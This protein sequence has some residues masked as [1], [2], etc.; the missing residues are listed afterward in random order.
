MKS[1][2]KKLIF[3]SKKQYKNPYYLARSN[4]VGMGLAFAPFPGQIPL[5][6]G[7]WLLGRKLKWRFSLAI[8]IMWSFIS[9]VFTNIPLFYLY[10]I[11]GNFLRGLPNTIKYED[12]GLSLGTSFLLGS[13]FYMVVFGALG[14]GIGIVSYKLRN[15]N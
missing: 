11:T 5:I 13:F 4:M 6:F 7:I 12:F 8:A 1:V 2:I 3:Y 14:Y 9:N 10:Y 15:F